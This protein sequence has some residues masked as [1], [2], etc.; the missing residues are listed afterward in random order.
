M[1][2]YLEADSKGERLG[3]KGKADKLIA[4]GAVEIPLDQLVW[5]PFL[6]CVV[7]NGPFEGAA[8]AYSAREYMVFKTDR[9]LRP[10][11][12]LR[13]EAACKANF[14]AKTIEE[15][16]HE[17][18]SIPEPEKSFTMV[19]QSREEFDARMRRLLGDDVAILHMEDF[20]SE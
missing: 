19:Y 8:F 3:T 12:W 13:A 4:D 9:T 10:K 15:M 16:W 7:D 11:R 1:G 6:V 5:Q 17:V 20:P 14:Q 18:R 2:I